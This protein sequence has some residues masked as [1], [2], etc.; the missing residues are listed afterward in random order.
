LFREPLDTSQTRFLA[1]MLEE[2]QGAGLDWQHIYTQCRLQGAL[3]ALRTKTDMPNNLCANLAPDPEI[4]DP[5]SPMAFVRFTPP[6]NEFADEVYYPPLKRTFTNDRP[7]AATVYY[8]DPVLEGFGGNPLLGRQLE[9]E[10]LERQHEQADELREEQ[11]LENRMKDIRNRIELRQM[12]AAYEAGNL[13]PPIYRSD[14]LFDGPDEQVSEDVVGNPN[15][16]VYGNNRNRINDDEQKDYKR[17]D[18]YFKV[19]CF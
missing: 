14:Q 15:E 12:L 19:C 8:P 3:Y 9:E 5:Q 7:K 13:K 17:T 1:T 6:N 10:I 2:L 11:A 16:V 18:S 4:L